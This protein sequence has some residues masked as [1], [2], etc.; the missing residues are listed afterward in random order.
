LRLQL[1]CSDLYVL[2]AVGGMLKVRQGFWLAR[3]LLII[4]VLA[5]V[6][7]LQHLIAFTQNSG[8]VL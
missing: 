3:V 1:A 4:I 8:K 5:H 2:N 6:F 7:L